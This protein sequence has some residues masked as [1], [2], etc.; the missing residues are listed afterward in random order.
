MSADVPLAA[1]ISNT[2]PPN[3]QDEPVVKFQVLVLMLSIPVC[4]PWM[5][6]CTA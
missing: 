6:V 5:P 2:P 4:P 3:T 1:F